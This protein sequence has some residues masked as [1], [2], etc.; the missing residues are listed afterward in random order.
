MSNETEIKHLRTRVYD[1]INDACVAGTPD[2][3]QEAQAFSGML[4]IATRALGPEGLNLLLESLQKG[5]NRGEYSSGDDE[6]G[7]NPSVAI[8]ETQELMAMIKAA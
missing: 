7:F 8:E 3:Y 4:C 1:L 2:M 6:D 5:L